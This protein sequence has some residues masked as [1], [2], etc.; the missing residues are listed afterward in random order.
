MREDLIAYALGE[1]DENQRQ[2][3]EELLD[4]DPVMREEL[5]QIKSCLG[6]TDEEQGESNG[7]PRGLAD[8]TTA[9]ILSGCHNSNSAE[10]VGSEFGAMKAIMSPLDMTVAMGILI[11]IGSLLFPALYSGRNQSQQLSCVNNLRQLGTLM[12]QYSDGNR[13]YYPVVHPYEHA[14]IFAP[15]LREADLISSCELDRLMVCPASPLAERLAEASETFHVPSLT[16]VSLAD[17]Q[18]LV[19]L[20][21]YSSGSY[22]YQPGHVR[23]NFYFPAKNLANSMVPVLSDAPSRVQN[24]R[25]TDN[26]GGN[27]VNVLFQDGTVRTLSQPLVPRGRDHLFLNAQGRPSVSSQWNDAV[28]LPSEF[29][30]GVQFPVQP[31]PQAVYRFIFFEK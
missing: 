4:S 23:G 2:R 16:D 24:F 21:R 5:A 29:T 6:H 18:W 10:T 1:L 20:K 22:G 19:E 25:S 11:T 30:P 14:G 26:H 17:G 9:G 28:V 3:V 31:M 8:R 7:V 12:T 13:G 15:R 27:R